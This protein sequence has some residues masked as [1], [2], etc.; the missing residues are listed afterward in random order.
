MM[1]PIDAGEMFEL[2]IRDTHVFVDAF[3]KPKP[4]NRGLR[5]SVRRYR[6]A[7]RK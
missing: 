5:D 1:P 6:K 7:T 4:V 3:V 2:S